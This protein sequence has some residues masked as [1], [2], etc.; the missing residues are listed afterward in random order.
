MKWR[1]RDQDYDDDMNPLR[2][3]AGSITG[4]TTITITPITND[5]KEKDEKI[6]LISL[7]SHPPE[8]LDEDGDVQTLDGQF[9][10]I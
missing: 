7:E 1:S 6:R 8:A 5:G 3:P 10:W 2:I 4:T 9:L